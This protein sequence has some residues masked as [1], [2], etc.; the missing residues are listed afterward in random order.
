MKVTVTS[1]IKTGHSSMRSSQSLS[2]VTITRFIFAVVISFFYA[3][4]AKAATYYV[5]AGNLAPVPPYTSWATAATNIQDAIAQTAN[6]DTVLVTNGVYAYGGTIM[7]AS[8]T[9]RVAITNAITV[10]SV[11]GPWVTSILGNTPGYP[12]ARCAWLT[13]GASLIGFT[14]SGGVAQSG[15]NNGGAIWC[16]SSNAS[17][18]NCV[19]VSNTA[20]QFGAGVYQGTLTACL[21][22]GNGGFAP[23]GA[24]YQAVLNNCTIVSNNVYGVVSPLAM[25]NCIVYFSLN[26]PNYSVSGNAFS[27]CC[28]IPALAGTGNFTNAP[29]FFVD[30]MHLANNSP[31]I[32]AGVYIGGGLDI[33]G[34]TYAN[35]PSVGCAEQA[36]T[37]LVA[38]PKIS[39]TGNPV[40]FSVGNFAFAATAPYN[41]SWLQNGQP[42]VDNGHFGGTQTSN[43]VATSVS[44]ADAGNYQVVVSNAFGA[45]TSSVATLVIHCVN[46]SG[47][48]PVPP[49]ASWAT[50]A[51]NIQDAI[52]ASLSGDVVLVTN[53]LYNTG[54]ESMDGVSTNRISINKAILVQS[55]NGPTATIIQGAW[56]PTSTNGPGAVRCVWMT[57][58]LS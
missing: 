9:N 18:Q 32:G 46:N 34:E 11:N 16:A 52:T 56:D 4:V 24:V 53:G 37:P 45:V 6:G 41:F 13:N 1:R 58:I 35:P 31:C 15:D 19:I 30:G 33:F 14:L 43:L 26:N 55:V 23:G 57:N 39:L 44:I 12:K 29:S 28:T 21:I 7:A 51:T 27:H 54:S 10:E 22:K 8:L 42:L 48:N 25:T 49:Y 47:V 50:A 38:A 3:H 40:G 20:A 5:N 17:L 2:A 36:S